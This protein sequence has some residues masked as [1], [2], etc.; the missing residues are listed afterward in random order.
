MIELPADSR[1][2]G[3]LETLVSEHR[4]WRRAQADALASQARALAAQH[5]SLRH[6]LRWF[7]TLILV[8][9]AVAAL[10]RAWPALA[11]LATG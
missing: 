8:A 6:A 2:T 3:L 7:G 1:V 5:A 4:E 11:W 9:A 10:D